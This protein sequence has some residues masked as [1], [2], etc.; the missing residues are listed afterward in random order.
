[1]LVMAGLD[2]V[3]VMVLLMVLVILMVGACRRDEIKYMSYYT[4]KSN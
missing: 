2:R 1:M 4:N 3:M